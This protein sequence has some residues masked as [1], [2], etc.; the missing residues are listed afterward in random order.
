MLYPFNILSP[1][2]SLLGH[3]KFPGLKENVKYRS[4]QSDLTKRCETPIIDKLSC[5][6]YYDYIICHD[7]NIDKDNLGRRGQMKR[8]KAQTTV[9]QWT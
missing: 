9:V 8:E 2:P 1:K 3:F 7:N 5:L 6:K 4:A